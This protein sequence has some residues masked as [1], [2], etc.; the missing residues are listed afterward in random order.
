MYVWTLHYLWYEARILTNLLV[1]LFDDVQ[2]KVAKEQEERIRKDN[3]KKADAMADEEQKRLVKAQQ[4]AE[5]EVRHS[6]A[7]KS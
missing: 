2:E 1:C 7:M 4:D 6:I 3:A 5:A